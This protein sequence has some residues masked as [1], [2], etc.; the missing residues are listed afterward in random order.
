ME[1]FCSKCRFALEPADFDYVS[2]KDGKL[3]QDTTTNNDDDNKIPDSDDYNDDDD[4]AGS[5]EENLEGSE[6]GSGMILFFKEKE[7]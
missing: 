4:D 5:D 6:D 3:L 1:R 7:L 2:Y